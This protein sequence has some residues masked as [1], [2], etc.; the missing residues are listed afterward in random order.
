MKVISMILP[1]EG[2]M[3]PIG[4]ILSSNEASGS[5]NGLQLIKLLVPGKA[6]GNLSHCQG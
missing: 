2:D 6:S 5:R 3:A 4:C 1:N